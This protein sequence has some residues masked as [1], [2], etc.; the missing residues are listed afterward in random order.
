[1]TI[2]SCNQKALSRK[3]DKPYG[4]FGLSHTHKLR[5]HPHQ[6]TQKAGAMSETTINQ[7]TTLSGAFLDQNYVIE[8]NAG[9]P[10]GQ[11][12]V[13][14]FSTGLLNVIAF[15]TFTVQDNAT[16]DMGALLNVGAGDQFIIGEN[17]TMELGTGI[18]VS[19]LN[20]VRFASGVFGGDLIVDQGVDLNLL[21]NVAG[22][23]SGDTIDLAGI[24]TPL[25][26]T[27]FTDSFNGTDTEFTIALEGGSFTSFGVLGDLTS[28]SFALASDGGDP[29]TLLLFLPCFT[30]GTRIL[31]LRGEI[32]VENLVIGD[33]AV[34]ADGATSPVV[35]IGHRRLEPQHHPRPETVCPVRIEAGALADGIPA[36]PLTLSPDHALLLDG[37]LVQAKDLVDGIAVVQ[38]MSARSVA[39][40]HVELETHGILLAEGAPAESFLNT[41]HRGLFENA[42]APLI[43]HPDLMQARREAESIAPL[44]HD[45]ARLAAI[46]AR[47]H[48]RKQSLGL[49]IVP[50]TGIALI[51]GGRTIAPAAD[52]I[53]EITFA[54]PAGIDEAIIKTASF[55]PAMFDPDSSDRRRLGLPITRIVIDGV[56]L[57][58]KALLHQAS[59]HPQGE[60][61]PHGWTRENIRLRIPRGARTLT[62]HTAGRPIAWKH[63]QIA[64]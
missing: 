60:G 63:G 4:A 58:L 54:L 27:S 33:I 24:G 23:A 46:R 17:G 15:S 35:F 25:S 52:T 47:L 12:V 51:A 21:S 38:D 13:V 11:P 64:A 55:I 8:Q 56:S 44:C 18:S 6:T 34:L 29:G 59:L 36:R 31:T 32:P 57:P 26:A 19:A 2:K 9:S 45:G 40:Y 14:G 1:M 10:P 5:Q 22:F 43:L 61:D 50:A 30:P 39:Y 49:E 53:N 37:V 20:D 62:L 28:D 3:V 48:A 41:G 42:G 16:L 7:S